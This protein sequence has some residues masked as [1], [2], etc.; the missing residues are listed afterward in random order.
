MKAAAGDGQKKT[1]TDRKKSSKENIL[2]ILEK[3]PDQFKNV[4]RVVVRV[5][6]W[7]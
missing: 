1:K 2:T 6:A 3:H 5:R 4:V 7:R